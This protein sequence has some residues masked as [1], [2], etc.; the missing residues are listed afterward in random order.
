MSIPYLSGVMVNEMEALIIEETPDTPGIV[1]DKERGVFEIRGRSLPE[2]SAEFFSPV[3]NW[4]SN[5]K[6]QPNEATNFVVKLEYL[7]TAS[8]K[9]LLDILLLL[10]DI[11]NAKITWY[12][13][14]DDEDMEEAGHEFSEQVEIP[15]V[16]KVFH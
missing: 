15:F 10:K 14:E 7:N 1:F 5:Y 9:F 3:L 11:K 8:S 16:F 4:I 13:L 12:F 2:D 6:E